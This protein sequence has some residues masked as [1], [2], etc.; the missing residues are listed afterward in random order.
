MISDVF[1]IK[2]ATLLSSIKCVLD[3]LEKDNHVDAQYRESVMG[4]FKKV[5]SI[6][7][8]GLIDVIGD[9]ETQFKNTT[10]H[11]I[12]QL[13]SRVTALERDINLDESYKKI[14]SPDEKI[15]SLVKN[16][17]VTEDLEAFSRNAVNALNHIVAQLEK[18]M[19]F[20]KIIENYDKVEPIITS[21]LKEKATL[22][23]SDLNVKYADKFMLLYSLKHVDA[24]FKDN[25]LRLKKRKKP[26]KSKKPKKQKK[27]KKAK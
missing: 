2:H 6:K 14:W 17:D 15:P 20:I 27:Q 16:I 25:E 12:A 13:N 5:T 9:M 3:I 1:N 8:P 11:I 22:S 26:K 19:A 10:V 4:L 21:K 23:G 18:D 24:E 7:D